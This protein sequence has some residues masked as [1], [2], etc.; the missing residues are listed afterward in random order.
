MEFEKKTKKSTALTS[1][2]RLAGKPVMV[3][4]ALPKLAMSDEPRH[5]RWSAELIKK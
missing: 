2:S 5:C 3:R 1:A 4:A